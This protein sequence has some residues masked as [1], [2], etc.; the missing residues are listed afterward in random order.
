MA[1]QALEA[2]LQVLQ[3]SAEAE[4]DGL[5]QHIRAVEDRANTEIDRARQESKELQVRLGTVIKDHASV[6]KML[7]QA[8]DQARASAV[9]GIRD[10]SIERA[11]ADA[12]ETQ[13]S[14]LQD[15]PAALEAAMRQARGRKKQS[16]PGTQQEIRATVSADGPARGS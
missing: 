7:R 10:A 15:L 6:E 11:R 12:L 4:R 13:L 2:R 9:E 16:K 3:A 5:L 14:K 8:A 1:R